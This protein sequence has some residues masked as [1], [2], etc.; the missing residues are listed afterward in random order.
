MPLPCP[1]CE[2]DMLP[3]DDFDCDRA[4]WVCPDCAPDWVLCRVTTHTNLEPTEYG[5]KK[6][7]E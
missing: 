7:S 2:T 1:D 3:A 6:D 5:Y 4:D